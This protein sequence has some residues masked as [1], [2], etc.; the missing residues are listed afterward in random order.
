[1]GRCMKIVFL[2]GLFLSASSSQADGPVK[3]TQVDPS[4]FP[5]VAIYVSVLDERGQPSAGLVREDFRLFED[6]KRVEIKDFAGA[7]QGRPVDIAFVFDTTGSM[8]DEI[9][10]VKNTCVA[11]ANKLRASNRDYRLGLV[12]FGDEIREVR[13]PGDELSADVEE[14]KGWISRQRAAG[15]GDGP[16][17]SL[18]GLKRASQMKY[19]A[20]TQKVLILITDAPPHEKGDGTAFSQVKTED[21]L[22][23]LRDGGYTVYAVARDDSRFRKLVEATHG[24]FLQL[25]RATDFTG[26][27]DKLGGLIAAQYRLTYISGRPFYDGTRR[28]IEV[29]VAGKRG[30]SSYLEKHLINVHSNVPIAVALLVPLL[31]ALGAPA[32]IAGIGGRVAQRVAA[33][34]VGDAEARTGLPDAERQAAPMASRVSVAPTPAQTLCPHCGNTLR[35]GAKFCG[36]CGRTI[37]SPAQVAPPPASPTQEGEPTTY[38]PHCGR[39]VRPGAR[40]CGGCGQRFGQAAIIF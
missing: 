20:N 15:G 13:G 19:R 1:M 22:A 16:E 12:T 35:S 10:G 38:C 30:S 5:E 23:P 31:L 29:E 34:A 7:A 39:P 26:I 25:S 2:I 8:S 18:D 6:G 28:A 21:L 17:I 32:I 27:I 40:F 4:L 3:V 14:F 9:E 11:F 37:A 33:Q 24:E 36:R